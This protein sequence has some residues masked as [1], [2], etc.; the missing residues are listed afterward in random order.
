MYTYISF[1]FQL[2]AAHATYL[3]QRMIHCSISSI[4][5]YHYL[6]QQLENSRGPDWSS[7]KALRVQTSSSSPHVLQGT[8]TT[9]TTTTNHQWSICTS[10]PAQ[11]TAAIII[12]KHWIYSQFTPLDFYSHQEMELMRMKT[13]S[14]LYLVLT[15][16]HHQVQLRMITAA[17]PFWVMREMEILL[18][19][20]MF[21]IMIMTIPFLISSVGILSL[22]II[23]AWSL[24]RFTEF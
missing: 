19:A 14:T 9:T 2:F 10:F 24:S 22:E 23:S 13:R 3:H 4:Q 12:K 7:Q 6:Q 15:V 5:R 20:V 11:N 1:I 18:M 21:M 8:T 17:A 16:L